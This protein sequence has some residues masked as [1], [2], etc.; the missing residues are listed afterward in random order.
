MN[1]KKCLFDVNASF[2]SH[3]KSITQRNCSIKF[4]FAT[5]IALN[6]SKK[7]NCRYQI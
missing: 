4:I 7:V 5:S 6:E 3:G 1:I 2:R